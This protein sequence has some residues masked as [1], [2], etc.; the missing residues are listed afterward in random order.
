MKNDLDLMLENFLNDNKVEDNGFSSRVTEQL[1]HVS[2]WLWLY[3]AAPA[4]GLCAVLLM[5]WQFFGVIEKSFF[6]YKSEF[7][8]WLA[9]KMSSFSIT[10]SYSALMGVALVIAYFAFEKLIR[11]VE[12]F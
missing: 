10:I 3:D 12:S 1:P 7:Y 5:A 6:M 4:F 9:E 8:I 2:S 11:E